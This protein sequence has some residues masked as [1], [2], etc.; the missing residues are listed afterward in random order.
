MIQRVAD[1]RVERDERVEL[2]LDLALVERRLA[3]EVEPAFGV[4]DRAA[5]DGVGQGDR[6]EM[7]RGVRAHA[8]VA[9]VP[10]DPGDDRRRRARAAPRLRPGRAGWSC[11]RRRRS[12]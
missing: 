9:P 2:A 10:V 1:R 7:Q 3:V 6:E 8:P 4:A 5:G 12:C 11:G